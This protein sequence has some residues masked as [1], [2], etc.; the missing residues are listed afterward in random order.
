LPAYSTT[1]QLIELYDNILLALDKKQITSINFVD[2]SKAFDTVW[3]KALIL[4]LKKY[5]IW[6][7]S[8]LSRRKQRVV[9]KDV[10]SSTWVLKAGVRQGSVLGPLLFLIFI[11]DEADNM[12]GFGKLFADDTCIGHMA[13]NEENLHT[14]ISIDLEYLNDRSYR[15]LVKFN[16]NKTDIMIFSTRH[17][18]NNSI[19]DFNNISLSPVHMHKHLGVIFSN[20]CKW[21]KHIDVLIERTSKQ[22][23]ILR[24]LKYRLKRNYL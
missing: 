19:F 23:N 12:T 16:S 18:E 17:S 15:W 4:K 14:L 6:L 21:T 22:L 2:I 1:H 10:I 5:G 3:I 11:N 13:H 8:Y 24:K 20:D 7:K 9:I